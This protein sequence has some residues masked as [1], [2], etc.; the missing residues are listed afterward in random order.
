M[1]RFRGWR[2]TSL[3]GMALFDD[4]DGTF[5]L[6]YV[7]GGVHIYSHTQKKKRRTEKTHLDQVVAAG[8]GIEKKIINLS[9]MS[10][11]LLTVFALFFE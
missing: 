2:D 7:Y 11:D 1:Q 6:G 10:C 8:V 5:G 4:D 3:H 9:L